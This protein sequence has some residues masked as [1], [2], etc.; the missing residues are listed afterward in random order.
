MPDLPGPDPEPGDDALMRAIAQRDDEAALAELIRRHRQKLANLFW[1]LGVY[2]DV[3]DLLQ[4]VFVRVWK[5]RHRWEPTAKVSTWLHT[6]ARNVRIDHARKSV[7][8]RA[9]H[10]EVLEESAQAE[11]PADP[12][13]RDAD[14]ALAGLPDEYR[15]AVV[16]VVS[17][18][19]KYRE[20][21]EVLGVPEG[22]VKSRVHEGLQRLRTWFERHDKS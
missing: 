20:A 15:E 1:R 17:Q 9:L 7:R 6:L 12:G 3:D 5:A 10:L 22:T 4:E 8:T 21:A 18:G 14:A 16:L 2:T 13:R 11:P 19:L